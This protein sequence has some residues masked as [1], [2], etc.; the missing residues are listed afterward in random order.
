[1][2]FIAGRVHEAASSS[3]A[4]SR[5]RRTALV[6]PT[7]NAAP[8]WS[9]LRTAL[10]R[11]GL[12]PRQILI[13]D[14]SS[15]DSTPSLVR[16]AGY[17]LT[18]VRKESFRHGTTRQLA[19]ESVPWAETLVY[20]TQDAI[21]CGKNAI[22][23]LLEAF[24]D[25]EVGAA[26]G[27]Q[28]PRED[29]GPIE[30]HARLFNYPEVSAVRTFAQ[31]T[32]LGVKTAFFSN[33]FA[34]YRRIALDAVGGFPNDTIVSEEVSVVARMLMDDWKIAYQADATTIHSHAF[35]MREEFARYFDIGIHR[36][37]ERQLLSQFGAADG[38]G[39]AFVASEMRFLL[40]T[41]PSLI[42][43]AALRDASKWVA[44]HLGLNE[45]R[46][47]FTVKRGL[48]GQPSFW[49]GEEADRFAKKYNSPE[50]PKLNLS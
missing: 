11:Q 50:H 32:R 17:Q 6:I 15:S 18:T 44:Y 5:L 49:L 43:V 8:F 21:P 9:H 14:S 16:R 45:R 23:K 46:L 47:P 25:P 42:P 30:R 37:R 10:D 33:S 13:V 48:S 3:A 24:D 36:G 22:F 34:A 27:R 29:A 35:T 40:K 4:D 20:L 39:R 41:R 12:R 38:E 31:R 1:M 2:S 28:L 7:Y 26:Y 19:A